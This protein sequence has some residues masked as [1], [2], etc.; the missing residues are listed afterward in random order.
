MSN[1]T[2]DVIFL[3]FL[4]FIT[5]YFLVSLI[6]AN[7]YSN[8]TNS[9]SKIYLSTIISTIVSFLYVIIYD[10]NHSIIS[11]NYYIGLGIIISTLTYAYRNNLGVTYYDWANWMIENK[12]SSIMI[13]ESI[14]LNQPLNLTQIKTQNIASNI[15]LNNSQEIESLKYLISQMKTD[16]VFY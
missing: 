4:T 13:S 11:C 7:I 6:T 12:S 5:Q 15:I 14:K 1:L 10:I 16:G 3:I 8:I 9:L 2:R